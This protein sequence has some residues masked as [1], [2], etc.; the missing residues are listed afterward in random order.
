MC[1]YLQQRKTTH[2]WLF[3]ADTSTAYIH[4]Y[5]IQM[6]HTR[7]GPELVVESGPVLNT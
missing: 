3:L 6:R 1:I 2:L 5:A 7:E 4:C